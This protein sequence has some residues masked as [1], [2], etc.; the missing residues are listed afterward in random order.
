MSAHPAHRL[1]WFLLWRSG[2]QPSIV[3]RSGSEQGLTI[4]EC[5]V[6]VMLIV[7]TI[8]MVAPPLVLA[9]ATRVQ[10][11]RAE[12]ALQVAQ[13]EVDRIRALVSTGQH[14]PASLPAS[15]A[16][17]TAGTLA[18]VA[19]PTQ[20]DAR[21]RS[22]NPTGTE[23]S[24]RFDPSSSPPAVAVNA[25]LPIDVDGDCVPEYLMQIFRTPGLVSRSEGATGQQ[26]RPSEFDIGIRVYPIQAAENF[27][28]QASRNAL[29]LPNDLRTE[30]AQLQLTSGTLRKRPLAAFYTKLVW[31]EERT[32]LCSFFSQADRQRIASCSSVFPAGSP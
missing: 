27:S 1:I 15:V 5:L 22:L 2:R 29:T 17:A 32:S 21:L 26:S 13:G 10:N 16:G 6:A 4:M 23:C 18:S 28:P 12:Q 30:P 8:A 31:T 20:I 24:N 7:I 25:V 11:R 3:S 9:T 19:A 14:A